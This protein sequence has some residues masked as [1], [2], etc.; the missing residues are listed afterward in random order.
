MKQNWLETEFYAAC[1]LHSGL[2]A[3]LLQSAFGILRRTRSKDK[4]YQI[5]LTTKWYWLLAKVSEV[6]KFV[7]PS[8][9]LEY[10]NP[11]IF[12]SLTFLE[13]RQEDEKSF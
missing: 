11:T 10:E 8:S 4:R 6:V 9:P 13:K 3:Q 7:L 1:C 2:E 5:I 12:I